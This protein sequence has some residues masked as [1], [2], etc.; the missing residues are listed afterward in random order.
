VFFLDAH[1]VV[2][3]GMFSDVSEDMESSGADF[4]GIGHRFD[5]GQVYASRCDFDDYMW[6]RF[7]ETERPSMG[8]FRVAT[9]PHGAFAVRRESYKK[10]GGY[11]MEQ[12]GYGGEEVSL[13]LKFWLMGMQCWA[14]P[15]T[16]HWHWLPPGVRHNASLFEDYNFV[17]N[18]LL[19]AAA[20]GDEDRVE[21]S[22][23]SFMRMH[24]GGRSIHELLRSHI[25]GDPAVLKEKDFVKKHGKFH[26]IDELRAH[27]M[28]RGDVLI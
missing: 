3:P 17:R 22:Y 2:P 27:W 24:W 28:E 8:P 9:Y 1:V 14:T 20:Y 6:S 11:W 5:G 16:Y 12:R 10:A 18:F 7:C 4:M 25:V 19:V 15:R 13:C 23:C 26:S 21:K